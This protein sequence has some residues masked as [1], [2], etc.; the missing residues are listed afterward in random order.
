MAQERYIA[1]VLF[2]EQG[3]CWDIRDKN[4][5]S[6]F[7]VGTGPG[8]RQDWQCL[9]FTPTTVTIKN[10]DCIRTYDNRGRVLNKMRVH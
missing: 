6:I 9:G 2:R 3:P 4:N 7:S 8:K 5:H 1:Y 10:A